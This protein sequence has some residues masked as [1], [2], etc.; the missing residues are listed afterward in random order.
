MTAKLKKKRKAFDHFHTVQRAADTYVELH[1]L[2]FCGHSSNSA[3]STA[4]SLG[5]KQHSALTTLSVMRGVTGNLHLKTFLF[6]CL[7]VGLF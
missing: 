4:A 5:E 6:V 3:S 1:L 7:F 2:C